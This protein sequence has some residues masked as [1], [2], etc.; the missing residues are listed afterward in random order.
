MVNAR[1][2]G[3]EQIKT[4]AGTFN[5]FRVQPE[6][7]SGVLRQKGRVWIW[8]ANDPSHTPVQMRARMYW[9]TL[10]LTLQRIEKK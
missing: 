10:T 1:V 2:E 4:P 9:G 7:A 3:T 5:T 6:A 8:Y